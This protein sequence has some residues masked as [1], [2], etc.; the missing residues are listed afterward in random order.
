M[1]LN[2]VRRISS[3]EP[4]KAA[5]ELKKIEELAK[6][7]SKEIRSMLFTLRPLLLES[8]GLGAALKSVMDRI[9]DAD[10][11]IELRLVGSEN[12]AL[13]NS[14]NQGVVFSIIEEALTNAR[15]YAKANVVEV[16]LWQED[17]LFVAR[18]TDDGV[19]F[20]PDEVKSDYNS[21][22]SL[23][24]INMHERSERIDGSL[25]I[26]SA[27]DAGTTVTLVVPLDLQSQNGDPQ[28]VLDKTA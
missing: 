17:D 12:G 10:N 18:I 16:R 20:D 4:E 14:M 7:T 15:K 19:G 26:E 6:R 22:G 3:S 2:Y 5:V 21:R 13:L 24:M 23:G 11:D 1:R 8:Q 25:S 9:H 28:P 27:P